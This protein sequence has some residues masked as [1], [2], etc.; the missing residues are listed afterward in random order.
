MRLIHYSKILLILSFCLFSGILIAGDKTPLQRPAGPMKY[1][2]KEDFN[3]FIRDMEQQRRLAKTMDHSDRKFGLHEGNKVRTLFYNYGSIGRPNTEPSL[4]WPAYSSHGYGY[5]FGPM[6]GAEVVDADSDTVTIFSDGML[7]GG[8]YD[9]NGGANWWGWEPLP[10]YAA[11]SQDKIAIST[12]PTTWGDNFPVDADGYLQWPGQFGNDVTVAD[13]ESYYI[14]DDRYNAEFQYYPSPSDS[15]IR[16]IGVQVTVR[17]YQYAASVAEDIIF[18]QYTVTNVSEKRLNKVVI[19]MIG[20]PHIGGAGDF[21]DDYAGFVNQDGIDSYTGDQLDVK[22]M[23]YCWDKEGSGNDFN[24]PWDEL[25]WLGYKFLESPGLA[26]DGIDNDHDGLVDESYT[27]GIDDDG[28]WQATDEEAAADT[29]EARNYYDPLMWNGID[30]DGDGRVDDWGDLDGKSDD[31][32]GNGVPDEGEPDYEYLDIDES[33]M[34]GLT[35]FWAPIYGTEEAQ[36]DDI[37]WRRMKPGTYASGADIAQEADNIFIFGTG[38][39]P[40]EPGESQNFS[41]ALVLGQGKDD[42]MSNAKVADWIYR[43]G[44]QFTKPPDKPE[45]VAVPGDGKVTLYW[46]DVAEHSVDPVNGEDFEGYKI[47][48]SNVKG[49][50]GN[51]ITDNQG[52]AFGNVPLAQFDLIDD[53][54]G[55][56]PI[57]SAE[58]YHM[59]MGDD[60]GLSR[61]FVDSNLVN[62]LKYYYAVTAYDQ[63]SVEGNLPPLEC[64]K[65]I[66]GVNV[67]EVIPNAPSLG[68]EDATPNLTHVEGFATA[69]VQVDLLDPVHLDSDKKLDIEIFPSGSRK[70]MTVK[71]ILGTDTTLAWDAIS[72]NTVKNDWGGHLQFSEFDLYVLDLDAASL[73]YT[74][75]EGDTEYFGYTVDVSSFSGATLYPRDLSVE[76]SSDTY[77]DTSVFI[78]PQ[79]VRFKI[80]NL[81]DNVQV[82]FI[83]SDNDGDNELSIGDVIIPLAIVHNAPTAT[84]DITIDSSLAFTPPPNGARIGIYVNKPFCTEGTTERYN[85]TFTPASVNAEVVAKQMD[86]IAVVPNPYVASSGFETPPPQ[87]FTYGRGDRRVDFIH[88]PQVCTIRIYTIAGEHVK[89]LEHAG[90]LYDGTESWDLLSKDQFDIAPGI[91]IYHVETPDGQERVGRLAIIK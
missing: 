22:S 41:I 83:F 13:F 91:Y 55:P 89:T 15:S 10:G 64:P 54:T 45:V 32:N 86:R 43:L 72:L 67:V 37:M 25:G 28:D 6:V 46:N 27:N 78:N 44:F 23:V 85:V 48:R 29:A 20:D 19:G 49:D 47:Y 5:E 36:M 21:A 62:G 38:Y 11:P 14:M 58:G 4:E 51:V 30:D 74:A 18:F 68:V 12:D 50:W 57:P 60:T 39:F 82:D 87:V 53:I 56:H 17:G 31:L 9:I 80:M 35:S 77:L 42:M 26:N 73:D 63:G 71:E 16:G 59:D 90:D 69:L 24:I 88:L 81:N 65:N 1:W 76:F 70:F 61:V 40:L 52:I 7:D 33:D 75:W 3:R 66:G 34:I 8:D 2:T 84:W 79:P